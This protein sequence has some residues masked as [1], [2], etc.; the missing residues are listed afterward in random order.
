MHPL[1]RGRIPCKLDGIFLRA[2]GCED[3]RWVWQFS[4]VFCSS[5]SSCQLFQQRRRVSL[6][7]RSGPCLKSKSALFGVALVGGMT[8]AVHYTYRGSDASCVSS[9]ECFV[10]GDVNTVPLFS[11]AHREDAEA[12]MRGALTRVHRRS[13]NLPSSAPSAPPSSTFK[14]RHPQRVFLH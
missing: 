11:D 3:E 10:Q 8:P 13:Y 7:A 2:E 14:A 5:L 1:R 6:C 12:R 9:S 4:R